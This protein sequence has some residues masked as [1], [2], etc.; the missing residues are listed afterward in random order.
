MAERAEVHVYDN[1]QLRDQWENRANEFSKRDELERSRVKKS[2]L[3]GYEFNTCTT[4][5]GQSHC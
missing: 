2:A 4:H 5:N 3:N 1:K